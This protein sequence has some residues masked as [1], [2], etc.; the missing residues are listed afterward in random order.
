MLSQSMKSLRAGKLMSENVY[1]LDEFAWYWHEEY[2]KSRRKLSD[3]IDTTFS[4]E[5]AN[6][7]FRPG[8]LHSPIA[9]EHCHIFVPLRSTDGVVQPEY[10]ECLTCGQI[11]LRDPPHYG[12]ST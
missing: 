7:A 9:F 4:M 6:R 10:G 3:A 5:R 2:T 1:I 12:Y 11:E 8:P